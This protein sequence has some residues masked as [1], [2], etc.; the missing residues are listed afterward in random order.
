MNLVD[1]Y[2]NDPE[3]AFWIV[4]CAPPVAQFVAGELLIK[5]LKFRYDGQAGLESNPH[6]FFSIYKTEADE[7]VINAIVETA[8]A[9]YEKRKKKRG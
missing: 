1:I 3:Y 9:K 6:D 4:D 8:L 7:A 2:G 5:K